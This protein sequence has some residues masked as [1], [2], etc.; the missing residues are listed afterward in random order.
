MET[1][2]LQ[3]SN[4]KEE[5]REAIQKQEQAFESQL[6][7]EKEQKL[8]L[9]MAV[10][11]SQK[12]RPSIWHSITWQHAH[13]LP[14]IQEIEELKLQQ[15][16]ELEAL[17]DHVKEALQLKDA[18]IDSLQQKLSIKAAELHS[19]NQLLHDQTRCLDG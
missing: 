11:N 9:E 15:Q 3:L 18:F 10:E 14:T 7:Q 8:A 13:S 4:Q 1:L 2:K 19:M 5:Y 6:Q 12:V 17:E 16:K